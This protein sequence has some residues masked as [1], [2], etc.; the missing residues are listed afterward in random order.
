MSFGLEPL[1]KQITDLE[2]QLK[3]AQKAISD[4]QLNG[5]FWRIAHKDD[6]AVLKAKIEA[7]NKILEQKLRANQNLESQATYIWYFRGFEIEALRTALL[8]P[9]KEEAKNPWATIKEAE[10]PELKAA[11]VK[12]EAIRRAKCDACEITECSTKY[13]MDECLKENT[14]P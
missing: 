5:E 11:M 2:K 1:Y 4:A 8:I 13:S 14:S 10:L 12:C 9:R 7:A 6:V 3:D